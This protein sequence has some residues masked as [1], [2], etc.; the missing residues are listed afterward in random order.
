MSTVWKVLIALALVLPIGAFVA[1]SLVAS[2][3]DEPPIADPVILREAP[4]ETSSK[5]PTPRPRADSRTSAAT[6]ATS[7]SMI[8]PEPATPRRRR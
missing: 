6:R 4:Q 2:S 5:P 1:G 7:P 3:A 8:A